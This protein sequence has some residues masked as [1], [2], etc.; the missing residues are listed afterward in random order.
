MRTEEK[1][2]SLIFISSFCIIS[3]LLILYHVFKFSAYGVDFTDEGY[4]LNWISNPF[5]Y[6][7]SL[8]QFGFIYYPLYNLVNEN[9]AWFRRIIYSFKHQIIIL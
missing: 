3:T 7:T 8:S 4:Y 2:W 5:L 1:D 6:K 9:I